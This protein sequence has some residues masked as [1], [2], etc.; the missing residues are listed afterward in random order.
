MRQ[1]IICTLN[2]ALDNDS[3]TLSNGNLTGISPANAHN[4]VGC[5]FGV[6]GGKWYW[7]V[8]TGTGSN[9]FFWNG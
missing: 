7:E 1:R 2:P 4:G 3:M 5:T 8:L 6:T 9:S